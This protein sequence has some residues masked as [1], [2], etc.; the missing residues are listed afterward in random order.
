M[1]GSQWNTKNSRRTCQIK[2]EVSRETKLYLMNT[3]DSNI[4]VYNISASNASNELT[5]ES[6]KSNTDSSSRES[7]G[8]NNKINRNDSTDKGKKH[9]NEP[10]HNCDPSYPDFCIP[11]PPPDLDCPEIP[12]NN[13]KVVGSEPHGFDRDG[14]G[15]R[16][17]SSSGTGAETEPPGQ[18]EKGKIQVAYGD[19]SGYNGKADIQIK[20]LDTGKT[21][22]N[23]KLDFGKQ[24]ASQ[25][26][27]CCVKTYD[28]EW[29]GSS[30]GDHLGIKVTG[31]GGSWQ[32][33]SGYKLKKGTTK[34]SITLDEIGA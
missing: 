33:N 23:A 17:E 30:V 32:D 31:D 4:L 16:C 11:S 14:D 1:K 27:H 34:V 20:N 3:L 12:H 6:V 8:S 7:S 10:S 25:G 9:G 26:D 2:M 18:P 22:V 28:F 29:K 21:L 13:F 19:V 15:K 5:S 24:Y